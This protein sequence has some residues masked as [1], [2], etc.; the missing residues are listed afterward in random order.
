MRRTES[1]GLNSGGEHCDRIYVAPLS[2]ATLHGRREQE[3][4]AAAKGVKQGLTL[5]CVSSYQ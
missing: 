5:G 1:M 4:A 2:V 3:C